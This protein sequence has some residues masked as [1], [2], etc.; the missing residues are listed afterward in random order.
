MKI[1]LHDYGGY[2]FTR[3]LAETLACRGYGIQYSY[4]ETTQNIKRINPRSS[5]SNL[6]IDAIHLCRS[7]EKYSYFQRRSCE[8]EHGKILAEHIRQF[9]PDV[10]ISANT[11]L[12]AQRFALKA[13]R[14]VNARFLFWFQDAI[15][16][17]ARKVLSSK[18]PIAGNFIGQYYGW[19]EKQLVRQSDLLILISGDFLPLMN[20]WGVHNGKVKVIP[21]WAPL[22]EIPVCSKG[23]PWAVAHD[24]ADPFVFLYAGILGLKH[25]PALFI[26]LSQAFQFD[27]DVRIV[28]VAEGAAADWLKVQKQELALK[29]LVVLP[30][31]PAEV[32]PQMLGAA[33]VLMSILNPDAGSYSVPSKVLSY[34]CA[35]RPLLLAVPVENLAARLVLQN[36]AGLVSSPLDTAQWV[37]NAK[38]LYFDRRSNRR[39]GN[40]ARKYAEEFFDIEQITDK[41]EAIF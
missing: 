34:M 27:P 36:D 9:H 2:P 22:K 33:D 16:I 7:F 38:S 25:N 37:R 18:I 10:V 35:S 39:R 4:S 3:Q 32:F 21:N 11:P 40:N 5:S 29:N 14:N 41:F 28:I 30:Y 6:T 15:S 12:D 24:L 8:M 26:Q 23:N 31:Q 1:L 20:Q 13:S 19:V 17:A